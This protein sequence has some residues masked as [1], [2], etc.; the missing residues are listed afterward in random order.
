MPKPHGDQWHFR[1]KEE[2]DIFKEQL[3][4][5]VRPCVYLYDNQL[6]VHHDIDL[7]QNTWES[8]AQQLGVPCKYIYVFSKINSIINRIIIAGTIVLIIWV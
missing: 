5:L 2:E 3:I 6:A 1:T 7:V 4:E 8:I